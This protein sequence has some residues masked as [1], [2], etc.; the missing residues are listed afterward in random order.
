MDQRCNFDFRKL[1]IVLRQ[2]QLAEKTKVTYLGVF[3][4]L[5][6]EILTL[7]QSLLFG[8][9]QWL[10]IPPINQRTVYSG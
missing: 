3:F 4:I 8:N 7:E 2:L 1:L 10:I 5:L 9:L 6:F